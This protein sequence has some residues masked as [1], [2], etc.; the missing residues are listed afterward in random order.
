MIKTTKAEHENFWFKKIIL[1]KMQKQLI[2]QLERQ[3]IA[4]LP[5]VIFKTDSKH[6]W[7]Y[8]QI[9]F[10]FGF[11]LTLNALD[12]QIAGWTPRFLVVM[13][14]SAFKSNF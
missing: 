7:S 11:S 2:D 9:P 14:L 6:Q 5:S 8:L 12:F 10:I 3:T 4:K 13:D 1:K